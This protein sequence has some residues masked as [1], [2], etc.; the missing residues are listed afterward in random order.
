[1]VGRSKKQTV[2]LALSLAVV[3]MV[4]VSALHWYWCRRDL[5]NS[6][7]TCQSRQ[8][9]ASVS[10][11]QTGFRTCSR[12]VFEPELVLLQRELRG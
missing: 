4:L 6:I 10:E 7:S 1:M 8:S 3:V 12:V 2:S 5:R 11:A 9:C